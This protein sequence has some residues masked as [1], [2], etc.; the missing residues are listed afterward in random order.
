MAELLSQ[1][2]IDQL[3]SET[4][5]GGEEEKKDTQEQEVAEKLTKKKAK[6][7]KYIEELG[8]RY[9]YAYK[10]PVIKK[11]KIVFNPD[12]SVD[13]IP[14]KT[15]VRTLDNYLEHLQ[16]KKGFKKESFSELI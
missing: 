15:V 12:L 10:S 11:E 4:L 5:G 3:L 1:K 7:F 6:N 8:F 9:K 2:E 13:T 16:Y 14:G